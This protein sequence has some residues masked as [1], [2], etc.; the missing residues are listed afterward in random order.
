MLSENCCEDGEEKRK[1][2]KKKSQNAAGRM[3][4][5]LY[6]QMRNKCRG[7]N[8]AKKKKKEISERQ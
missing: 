3:G 4:R 1:R 8:F 5:A 6:L 7:S 2:R